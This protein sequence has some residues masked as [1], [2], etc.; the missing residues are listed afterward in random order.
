MRSATFR[1]ADIIR[2]LS[3]GLDMVELL[4][5][6]KDQN[7]KANRERWIRDAKKALGRTH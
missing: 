1:I 6:P 7:R 4:Y 2:L 3:E 5:H